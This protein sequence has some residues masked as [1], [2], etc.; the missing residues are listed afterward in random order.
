MTAARTPATPI[1]LASPILPGR[2]R[3]IHSPTR[4]AIGIVMAIVNV[5]HE[6]PRSAFT[7]AIPSPASATTTMMRIATD[8]T[9]PASGLISFR[10]ISASD[11]P[12]RLTDAARMTKSWTAP[13]RQTP[14][15]SQRKPGRKPNCAAR[16]G[17]ISGPAPEIAAK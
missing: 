16:T 10:A 15:R 11:R 4:S 8:P 1:M 12:F 5:P 6:L 2:T 17:P 13:P 3:Y 9:V 7:T 14:I